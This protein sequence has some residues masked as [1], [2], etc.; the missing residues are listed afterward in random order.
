MTPSE[1]VITPK[2]GN[3]LLLNTTKL[4][5]LSIK[6]CTTNSTMP[7]IPT[8]RS[9]L[10]KTPTRISCKIWVQVMLTSAPDLSN[11]LMLTTMIENGL[12]PH[13]ILKVLK[14]PMDGLGPIPSTPTTSSTLRVLRDKSWSPGKMKTA[15]PLPMPTTAGKVLCKKVENAK[16]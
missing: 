16:T 9:M 14:V 5:R 3:K 4:W 10:P 6:E 7:S 12:S 2:P 13:S 8:S 15:P 11:P 1:M